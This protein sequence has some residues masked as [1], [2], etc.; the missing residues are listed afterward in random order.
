MKAVSK[1]ITPR[2]VGCLAVASGMLGVS[3][4]V[5]TGG[6]AAQADP[7]WTSGFVG[8]G[9]VVTQD[10]W[11]AYTGASPAPS[12][13]D[14]RPSLSAQV[15]MLRLRHKRAHLIV[16]YAKYETMRRFHEWLTSR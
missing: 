9:A 13:G 14:V 1:L 5:S 3:S 6:G 12:L 4:L 16:H 10:L 7:S 15:R 2:V 8:V 11:A